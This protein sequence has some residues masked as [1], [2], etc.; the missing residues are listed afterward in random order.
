MSRPVSAKWR[1]PLALVLGGTLAAVFVLPVTAIGYFRVAGGV[2]GW[3]ET[4]LLI[5]GMAAVA[6]VILG[7]LLWR[8]VLRPVRRLTHFAHAEG[9]MTPPSQF[10][11][12]EFSA[13]GRAFFEMTKRFRGI[14]GGH[15]HQITILCSPGD[16]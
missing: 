2:L 9:D 3:W 6:T 5:A 12:P 13:L 1:P 7:W 4:T 14:F 8:L 16:F 10:G 11:T 15:T